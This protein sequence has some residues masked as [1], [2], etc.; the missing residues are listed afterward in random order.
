MVTL[1]LG[2]ISVCCF[3]SFCYIDITSS[4]E[5]SLWKNN[6][7]PFIQ[8]VYNEWLWTHF[9]LMLHSQ[10]SLHSQTTSHWL[11]LLSYSLF[12][13]STNPAGLSILHFSCLFQSY[14][15]SIP[16]MTQSLIQIT[17]SI[18]T[19]IMIALISRYIQCSSIHTHAS[20][21][22][23]LPTILLNRHFSMVYSR[24][25]LLCP[26]GFGDWP[27]WCHTPFHILPHIHQWP[28]S[29]CALWSHSPA[30]WLV[31]HPPHSNRTPQCLL[32][33]CHILWTQHS[34]HRDWMISISAPHPA[35]P[36]PLY[37]AQ[38]H[39]TSHISAKERDPLKLAQAP[40]RG[41]APYHSLLFH[42]VSHLRENIPTACSGYPASTVMQHSQTV[43]L[44]Q[45]FRLHIH[46]LIAFGMCAQCAFT[47]QFW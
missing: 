3:L 43:F 15:C 9:Q 28:T 33:W 16:M 6:Q 14:Y 4:S 24:W 35:L 40:D 10:K 7:H 25:A 13:S 44:A 37:S 21:A 32:G 42:R 17:A 36:H 1:A 45:L 12:F 26:N 2:T 34:S 31:R 11:W 23:F 19:S 30:C 8:D 41:F 29:F 27:T 46:T 38:S 18:T 5:T 20:L 22:S 47:Q 39:G